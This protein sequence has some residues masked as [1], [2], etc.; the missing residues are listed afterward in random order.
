MV[1]GRFIF[2]LI[3]QFHSFGRVGSIAQHGSA[4]GRNWFRSAGLGKK[5]HIQRSHAGLLP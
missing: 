4:A 2:E 5:A 3:E 1:C